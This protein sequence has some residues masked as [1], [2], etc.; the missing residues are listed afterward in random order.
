MGNGTGSHA[1]NV[2]YV[3][4]VLAAAIPIVR[5]RFISYV[6][7]DG[8][9]GCW[10]WRGEINSGGYGVF[11]CWA[12][13]KPIS[14]IAHRLGLHLSKRPVPE[15]LVVDHLCR[16][17]SCVNPE[18]LEAVTQRENILRGQGMGGIN[19]RKTHCI[20]GHEF[21][22]ANTRMYYYSRPSGH[23][24]WTRRCL[25]CERVRYEAKRTSKTFY[26]SR[27]SMLTLG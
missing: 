13:E 10:P 11:H 5:E 2:N 24:G 14:L 27:R 19:S 9:D 15:E 3:K 12:D 6:A 17:R 22:D 18:H 8:P 4:Y 26:N 25:T 20:H 23:E 21:S 16:N 7:F 1:D